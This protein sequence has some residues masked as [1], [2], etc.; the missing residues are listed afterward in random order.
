MKIIFSPSTEGTSP[1]PR[2][3]LR[4]AKFDTTID[5]C[6]RG[7]ESP[8]LLCQEYEMIDEQSDNRHSL[9][10]IAAALNIN[11]NEF[12]GRGVGYK[13]Y[14]QTNELLELWYRMRDNKQ[15]EYIMAVIRDLCKDN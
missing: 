8:P 13:L 2:R 4:F 3:N 12:F 1:H 14:E 11:V 10:R 6:I 5:W 9:E 15:R 7:G